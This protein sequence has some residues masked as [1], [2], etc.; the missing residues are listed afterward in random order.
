[1]PSPP[2]PLTPPPSPLDGGNGESDDDDDDDDDYDDDDNRNLMS[3]QRF[4]LD[5]PQRTAVAVGTN[6]AA[7]RVPLQEK[8]FRFSENLSKVFPEAN[9][10]IES[11]HQ[12]KI[13]E[14][15]GITVSNVQSMIKELNKGK[16]LD[17]LKLFSGEVKEE[18]LLQTQA[19]K[20]VGIL[21]KG[22]EEF[23]EYLASKYGRDVLQK[24]KLKIRL[25]SGEIYQ[26]NIN[27]SEGLYNFLRAQENVS[28]KI[29]NLDINL[30]GDLEY[31]IKEILDG[32]TVDKFGIQINSTSK[33]LFHRFNSFRR[34]FGLST[35][36]IRHIQ[37][38]DNKYA[39]ET[40]QN[41][42]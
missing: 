23:L 17:Q 3:T 2:L 33:F 11:D 30:S 26:D 35:F 27:T 31:Y 24:N 41:S 20:K 10:V 18:N 22:N 15:E 38:S 1:M 9:D 8:K 28:K 19:H 40:L 4:L 16:L 13:L 39:L 42:S 14:K 21:S 6:N 5:Q 7:M 12:P 34:S 25:E 32:V 37:V 29:L 36:A